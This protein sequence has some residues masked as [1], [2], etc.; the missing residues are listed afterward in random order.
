VPKP[1]IEG[2]NFV[3]PQPMYV[4]TG[5]EFAIPVGMAEEIVAIE[6]ATGMLP[7]YYWDLDFVAVFTI[8]NGTYQTPLFALHLPV[9]P[10]PGQVIPIGQR[11]YFVQ[12]VD[13][14]L[15]GVF[16]LGLYTQ[17]PE[18]LV[19]QDISLGLACGQVRYPEA[20]LDLDGFSYLIGTDYGPGYGTDLY[21]AA[22][23]L[24]FADLA[25]GAAAVAADMALDVAALGLL[26]E[27]V[28]ADALADTAY[29]EPESDEAGSDEFEDDDPDADDNQGYDSAGYSDTEE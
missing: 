21:F 12:Y 24:I 15:N 29:T 22:E 13:E 3:Y 16:H 8:T 28:E 19:F 7:G 6:Y 10:M 17:Y 4:T 25:F 9:P 23:G 5:S 11:N 18:R 14:D 27:A 20:A 26:E 1:P 2:T